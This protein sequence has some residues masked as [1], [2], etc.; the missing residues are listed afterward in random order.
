MAFCINTSH[1]EYLDLLASTELDASVLK[2]KIST[3]MEENNVDRFPTLGELNVSPSEVN[4]TL[5]IV[6]ALPKIQRN[7][8]TKEKLQGWIND[9]QKQGI[10][11]QQL[12]LFKQEAKEG[13]TKDEIAAAIA[14][15][16]S[17]A[18][19][20]N[21]TTKASRF[22]EDRNHFKIGNDRYWRDG[23]TDVY[24]KNDDV[25]SKE[26]FL[27]IRK[28]TVEQE[29]SDFYSNLTV[30]G[31]TN[32]TE[33]EIAT[34]AITPS[35]KG[36]AQFAT[37]K[38]IGWFRSD[39]ATKREYTTKP[40][41]KSQGT[42]DFFD[43]DFPDE[44]RY[45]HVPTKT[46][47]I[48]EVQSDLFQ[49]GRDK[50]N[51]INFLDY[52]NLSIAE[53]KKNP[54]K[55]ILIKNSDTSIPSFLLN[56]KEILDKTF[57]S[58]EEIYQYFNQETNKNQFLQLLNKDN[59]WVT[60]FVKSIIQDSAKKGYEK[61]LFP[62]G[63]TASKVEGHT[64]LEEFKK[65]K[66]N[67]IKE[68]ETELKKIEE[69]ENSDNWFALQYKI[70]EGRIKKINSD[71]PAFTD[72]NVKT[73]EEAKE[74]VLRKLNGRP[75]ATFTKE[76]KNNEIN[77]LKQELERVEGPEGFGALKPIW[78]FYENTVTNVLNKQFGKNSVKQ[79][80]DEYG[81]TWNEVEIIPSRDRAT[82]LYQKETAIQAK[83]RILKKV[84]ANKEGF[85]NP[86][87]YGEALKLV[88][89]FNKV[90]GPG[91]LSFRKASN[92][93]YYIVTAGN[94][95]AQ[96]NTTQETKAPVKELEDKLRAWAKSNDIAIEA[97]EDLMVRFEG[98]YEN[99]ILGVVDFMNQLIGLADGRSIDTLPE[100]VAHFA[101]RILKDRGD[102]SVLRA[103]QNVHLTSEYGEVT[104]EYKDVYTTEEE[105]REEALGKILAKEIVKQFQNSETANEASK[106]IA[107]YVNA[108]KTKF[109]NWVK[110]IFNKNAKARIDLQNTI[111]PIAT[112]ILNNERIEKTNARIAQQKLEA[113]LLYQLSEEAEQAEPEEEVEEVDETKKN[114]LI[115]QK[116]AF[117]KE[118]RDQLIE[119]MAMLKKGAKSQDTISKIEQEI[120]L[121]NHKITMGELDV[122]INSFVNL[123]QQELGSVYKILERGIEAQK[124]NPDVVH[125]SQNFVDMYA[126]LF[127]TFLV[128]IHEWGIP[129]EERDELVASVHNATNLIGFIYP[130]IDA[131][132]KIEGVRKLVEANTDQFGNKIDPDFDEEKAF[133]DTKEDM[134]I[135]RL[136]VGNFKYSDSKLIQ[137]ATRIIFDSI[138]R[139]KR[140][141][142]GTANDLLA[143]QEAMLKAGG[144]IEDLVEHD[145][146][147]KPTN[148]LAREY[149]WNRYYQKLAETKKEIAEKLQFDNYADINPAYLS[150]EDR[151][152]YNE[153]WNSFFKNNSVEKTVTE[154]DASGKVSSFKIKVPNESYKNPDFKKITSNPATKAYYDLLIAKKTEAVKK[155]PIHYRKESTVYMLP[156]IL[157]ST[158]DRLSSKQEGFM[159]KIGTL[160]RDSMFLDPDDTQF[161]QVSVLNNKMVPIFFIKPL[162]NNKD[163]SY[164]LAKTFS[165]F[166]EMAENYQ[167]M[168]KISGDLGVINI[169][170]A[171]KNYIK[172]N[173]RKPG[174]EGANEYKA[175]ETLMDTHVFGIQ[176]KS[177]LATKP[178]PENK[179]TTAVGIAGKQFSWAKAS[180]LFSNFIKDNNL[181]LNITTALSGFLK[182][183]GD[184]IIDDHVGLYTTHDSKNWARMEF[185]SNIPQVVSE[186][187]RAKQTN[188]MHL[189]LQEN[190]IVTLEKML[191]NTT[192]NRASRTVLNK[193]IL[194]STYATGDYG[195][196]GR[197]TLALY[198]NHRLYKGKFITRAKFYEIT[199]KEQ[200]VANDS[201]HQK[202]VKEQWKAMRKD[203]LYNAYEVVNGKLQVKSEFEQYVTEGVL[204][205]VN[206][207]VDHLTHMIDGT[208]S[209]TD[210]GALSRT[211]FGDYLLMH[212]GWFIG[213]VDTRFT[214]QKINRITEE[215]E[216]GTY[217]ATA[218]FLWNDVAGALL[219]DKTGLQGAMA[220]WKNLSPARKRGVQKT[221]LDLLY[222]NIVAVLA[223]MA[224]IAAD[225][226][227]DEDWTTQ[228]AAYQLNRLLLEQG[229]AWS[230]AEL[231][232]MIDEPVVGARMIKDLLDMSEAINFTQ[233]Y[234][235]GMYE[236]DSHAAKWWFKKLPIRNLYEMQY[237]EMKNQ[238]IKQMVD[239]KVYELM[240][241][242]QK[243]NV[244]TLGTLKNWLIPHGLT[245]E[246]GREFDP[247]PAAID[248]LSQDEETD[249]GFN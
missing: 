53:S 120:S 221:A 48:L 124:I 63:N 154:E 248:E 46:R 42:D 128:K 13:M 127:R 181:A 80:T 15:N 32:Y 105:F 161:G 110:G 204:N 152:V 19:E 23:V 25:I 142:V 62:S 220:S 199:A 17:Y 195:L 91:T 75:S 106:G 103:I 129:R 163:L 78:N 186:I 237:P 104:E 67:R 77:Q 235:G 143:A 180:K 28:S 8:F 60:F 132:A 157:K 175:L 107:A 147:N 102:I 185:A 166:S 201:K 159:S 140:F 65:Q 125:M 50:E 99:N 224:N 82:I 1:P 139:V 9:L 33:Q 190:Q 246:I 240:S 188:K 6:K 115:A 118:A 213:M 56:E 30:P 215:E 156:S 210:K 196:K 247:V 245:S 10:S 18:I 144:K 117:L 96:Q 68:L 168:N 51:L 153:M 183:S 242:R 236:G 134:S 112:S 64:T 216:I 182:G 21:T 86:M 36:H 228:Y 209:A 55:L 2:A 193:D 58:E 138:A 192:S 214:R 92:G 85:I 178:I 74:I 47:R 222:L 41:L 52:S 24:Y 179:W 130:K 87:K 81:N 244:G 34:P 121:L 208:L 12:E 109:I 5:R 100:E 165:L 94:S 4:Q 171:Q 114:K 59:N 136:Q 194:Y 212:R 141:A 249:N 158:V 177:A 234:E 205:S 167:E 108:I 198:D 37:D 170:M 233:V 71:L 16:Y 231:V 184:A 200:N 70:E 93:N 113:E 79:V 149:Y 146:N 238:F 155:L 14:A 131:L 101:I 211:I 26:Q 189:I 239:S 111:N 66:E 133:E 57:N 54:G 145:A 123:A 148:Y 135:Y 164:D 116:E 169:A 49:K 35:I 126:N 226:S 160:A 39:D 229:A 232:Q 225:G 69:V 90:N 84:N 29:P 38:G 61:V 11:S 223:A 176:S 122:A 230:P 162:K 72:T 97:I 89:D 203:S 27:K 173:V 43:M 207:K 20:I 98:R 73:E 137:S 227:D 187:G 22:N 119:R 172:G 151:K 7:I 83:A 202:S 197:T 95:L 76:K 191:Y 31:G 3:W 150:K 241:P 174:S 218:S 88:G 40:G 217:R 44:V 219:V 243:A 45:T 206:G